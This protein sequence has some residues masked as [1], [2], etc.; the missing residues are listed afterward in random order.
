MFNTALLQKYLYIYNTYIHRDQRCRTMSET[1]RQYIIILYNVPI[2]NSNTS[3]NATPNII[4]IYIKKK[5]IS[6]AESSTSRR[7]NHCVR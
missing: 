7:E 6:I 4:P 1:Q 2:N 5:T 3:N